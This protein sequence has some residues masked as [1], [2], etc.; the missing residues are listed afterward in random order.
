MQYCGVL[1]TLYTDTERSKA[2]ILQ[3]LLFPKQD[4]CQENELYFLGNELEISDNTIRINP[5]GTFSTETYFNSFSY[6][7]WKTYTKIENVKVQIDVEGKC[8]IYLCHAWID[9]KNIIRRSGDNQ[10]F[11]EK[12]TEEREII[13]FEFPAHNESA[14][15]H[16][17]VVTKDNEATIYQVNFMSDNIEPRDIKLAVGICTFRREEFVQKNINT[18]KETIIENKKSPLYEKLDVYISDNGQ[19][20]PSDIVGEHVKVFPNLN[21]GGSGGFTRC[22]IEIKNREEDK[23]Y[24]HVI[25]MD[26]DIVFD[27]SV[28]VRNYVF[29]SALKEEYYDAMIGG[30]MLVLNE[31]FRQFENGAAYSEGMLHFENKNIDLRKL[32]FVIQNERERFVNYNAWCYCCMP[33]SKIQLDNLP[34][35]FFIH[36]DDVEY[37]VRNKFKVITMNGISVW[38]PFFSNQRATSIVYYDVRNKLITMSELGGQHIVDYALFYLE[39]FHRYIF[40]YDYQR[41]LVACKAIQDFC[42]GID[43]FKNI[44][45]LELQKNLA[46]QNARWED[47]DETIWGRVSNHLSRREISKKGLL[48]NYLLPSKNEDVVMDCDISDA[49]PY[50]TKKL[51]IYNK[52]TKKYSVYKRSLMKLLQCKYEC[53]KTKK[54]IQKDLVKANFEWKDR[55]NEITN[56][57]FWTKYLQLRGEENE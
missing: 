47:A 57:E 21:L 42:K 16:I 15:A 38:H 39:I 8:D 3:N 48:I 31:Q 46:S 50:R 5:N 32:R 27:S 9:N 19:T 13:L 6:R 29:L 1:H 25:L 26:D 55:I 51:I 53:Y 33:L 24:T 2:L 43:E 22:L 7:K 40:N 28:L 17:K 56:I 44:D 54:I 49:F 34:M 11:Y 35:P 20:L 23:G 18:L 12:D 36:M 45:A 14:I 10:A 41:T 52:T 30:G 4:I 37:G